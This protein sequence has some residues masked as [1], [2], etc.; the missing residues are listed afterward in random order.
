M[1][2]ARGRSPRAGSSPSTAR[3]ATRPTSS[4]AACTSAC[5]AGSTAST[6]SPLV[7]VPQGQD[8]LRLRPRRRA[9][10][11]EPDARPRRRLQQLPGRPR[12]PA[13]R[14]RTATRAVRRAARPAAR[15]PARRR[16]RHQPGPVRRHHR[17]RGLPPAVTCSTSARSQAVA[18]WQKE[19]KEVGRVPTRSSSAAGHG[20]PTRSHPDKAM[21]GRLDRHRHGPRR[22]VA[23]GGR[24]HRP[25]GRHRPGRRR[26]TTT[27]TRTP[28]RSS[29]PAAAAAGSTSR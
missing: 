29:A 8:R 15:H 28:R 27:T 22:P 17:G 20:A 9:A 7:T 4:A 23:A 11:A 24:D 26:T 13:A 1:V 5:G 3:P 18:S 10:A 16:L 21:S 14:P 6:R 2:A 12:L 19:L 25:G